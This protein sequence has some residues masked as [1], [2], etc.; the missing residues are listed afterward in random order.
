MPKVLII[1]D[2][3]FS[4]MK[5]SDNIKSGGFDIIEAG[6]GEEGINAVRKEKPDAVIC[7]LLM[8]VMDGFGFLEILREEKHN[9]PVLILTS[10]IQDKTR[11][12]TMELGAKGL[13][14]KPPK[15]EE[16]IAK[17]NDL[18]GEAK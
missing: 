13:L 17:L 5:L 2:S 4:R 14:N 18:L 6:N 11:Q 16:V 8:P 3:R 10:D 15:Y 7:D 9:I 12:K 1:D